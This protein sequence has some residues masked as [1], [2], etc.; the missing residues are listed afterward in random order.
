[1]TY[2][3]FFDKKLKKYQKTQ[4]FML[5][6]I[7]LKR[8]EKTYKKVISKTNLMNMSKNGKSAYFR[9]VFANNFFGALKKFVFS[10]YHNILTLNAKAHK[11]TQKNG[12]PFFV[13]IS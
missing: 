7:P 1:M 13:N 5:N 11:T 10:Y 4:N 9:H 3:K 12:N 8:F 6:S 2:K